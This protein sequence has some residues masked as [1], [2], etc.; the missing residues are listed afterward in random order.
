MYENG[1]RVVGYQRKMLHKRKL[2]KK[3]TLNLYS[4]YGGSYEDMKVHSKWW[5]G[6]YWKRYYVSG[7]RQFARFCSERKI[8]TKY[9]DAINVDDF[10]ELYAPQHSDYQKEFD[11]WWT[12]F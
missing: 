5:D 8:R 11:F 12:V 7:V 6:K 9:R 1:V 10:E 4:V 3:A 2:K